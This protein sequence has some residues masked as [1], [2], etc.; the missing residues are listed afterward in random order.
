M[1]HIRFRGFE[2]EYTLEEN[3]PALLARLAGIIGCPEDW[4]TMEIVATRFITRPAVPMVEVLWFPRDKP[5]RDKVALIFCENETSGG[6]PAPV[7]IFM[8][9]APGDYYED[10]RAFGE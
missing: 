2:D 4:I 9:I 8:P 1:P 10:G 6:R 5:V 7:V 3:A